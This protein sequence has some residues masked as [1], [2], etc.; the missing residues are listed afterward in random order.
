MTVPLIFWTVVGL[1]PIPFWHLLLHGALPFWRRHPGGFYASAAA[2]WA[3][4]VPLAYALASESWTLFDPPSGVKPICLAVSLLGLGVWLWSMATL[5][6]RR[7]FAWAVLRPEETPAEWIRS[8]PYRFT[9]HPC[10]VALV[11]TTAA[12]F[13]ASGE[14]VLVGM[15]AA[16]A[17]LLA[18]VGVLEQREL[19]T[20]L[21]ACSPLRPALPV[22]ADATVHP[23]V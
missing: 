3:A 7:F 9:A 4:F 23:T 16:M 13:L 1:A 5:T 17:V 21:S 22:M 11:A 14:V 8:G 2:L 6:P 18:V 12:T 10:Y 19:K 20:R 15:L